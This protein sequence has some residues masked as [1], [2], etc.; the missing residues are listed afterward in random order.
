[1]TS[2]LTLFSN[3]KLYQ[4]SIETKVQTVHTG[5]KVN[6]NKMVYEK[7]QSCNGNETVDEQRSHVSLSKYSA[8]KKPMTVNSMKTLVL[9]ELR[10]Y[11]A[12]KNTKNQ[13]KVKT[14][15]KM[16]QVQ[17]VVNIEQAITSVNENKVT[18]NLVN[19]SINNFEK[20]NSGKTITNYLYSRKLVPLTSF[21]TQQSQVPAI[22]Y[23][24]RFQTSSTLTKS[25]IITIGVAILTSTSL[26]SYT[27][28]QR[29]YLLSLLGDTLFYSTS[30][31]FGLL[32]A[33][34]V[35]HTDPIHM[36]HFGDILTKSLLLHTFLTM[37]D[38]E[39]QSVHLNFYSK[40]KS[41]TRVLTGALHLIAGFTTNFD[42]K[43][44]IKLQHNN[45]A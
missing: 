1:M 6:I 7:V 31:A 3:D 10:D 11:F 33:K 40:Q 39:C 45:R 24:E 27:I 4:E 32:G 29:K 17:P 41:L 43:N 34:I 42:R 26:L 2:S 18:K 25:S 38:G 28:D 23:I 8:F 37:M 44:E 36:Q 16:Y 12:N 21:Y 22:S 5:R 20:N 15:S 19:L 35:N 13:N 14:K 30:F 9:N